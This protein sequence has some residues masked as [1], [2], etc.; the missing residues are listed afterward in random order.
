MGPRPIS[1]GVIPVLI[2]SRITLLELQW[3]R[4]RSVAECSK[5]L[6][7]P[8]PAVRLQWGRDRS[9]AEWTDRLI[10]ANPT[11]CASMGPRPISRGVRDAPET[12][13][14]TGGG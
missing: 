5:P 3:G 4:D 11:G 12:T 7:T 6:A 1:R 10:T 9:V 13:E 14:P 8:T 2:Q